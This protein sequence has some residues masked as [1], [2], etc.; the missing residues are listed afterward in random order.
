MVLTLYGYHMIRL[1]ALASSQ[2]CMHICILDSTAFFLLHAIVNLNHELF[3]KVHYTGNRTALGTRTIT[4]LTLKIRHAQTKSGG[5][6]KRDMM[7]SN[8]GHKRM[9]FRNSSEFSQTEVIH[10]T[11]ESVKF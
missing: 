8:D 9:S 5:I 10:S 7:C 11:K 6:K 3:A 4:S 1:H 2:G